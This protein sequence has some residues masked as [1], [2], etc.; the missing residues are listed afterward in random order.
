[1]TKT[2]VSD[3][4][5]TLLKVDVSG[6]LLMLFLRTRPFSGL[7]FVLIWSLKGRG[8]VKLKLTEA[9]GQKLSLQNLPVCEMALA[10]IQQQKRPRALVSGSHDKLVRRIA[11]HWE[12]VFD[13]SAGSSATVN[14]TGPRK[15]AYLTKNFPEGFDYL[16]DSRVDLHVW[17]VAEKA[18]GIHL[19]KSVAREA[20]RQKINLHIL[21]Y[22][23]NPFPALVEAARMRSWLWSLFIFIPLSVTGLST[24]IQDI[25][26]LLL[27]FLSFSSMSSALHLLRDALSLEQ[28]RKIK[29]RQDTPLASGRLRL[30]LG[31]LSL[32]VFF[33]LSVG[34]AALISPSFCTVLAGYAV[35]SCFIFSL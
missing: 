6:E 4:D 31:L 11:E 7:F 35:F 29:T 8:Y 34:C 23:P 27:A 30:P 19:S 2:F 15:A 16:G 26:R 12:G 3:L 25:L 33:V 1:M 20:K 18:Y 17:K 24:S 9:V 21:S 22:K 32:V 28:D 13:K 5:E 14:L 10:F